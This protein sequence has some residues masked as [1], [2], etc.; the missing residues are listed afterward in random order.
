[1]SSSKLYDEIVNELYIKF[2]E[3]NI[4]K[5]ELER[6]VDSQFRVMRDSIGRK[7]AE[8]TMLQYLG[9]IVPSNAHKKYVENKKQI[10]R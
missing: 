1:M 6:I 8:V 5:L 9:K 7:N 4:S 10:N 2:R 3:H